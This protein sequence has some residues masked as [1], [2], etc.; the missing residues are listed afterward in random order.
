MPTEGTLDLKED[1]TQPQKE[2]FPESIDSLGHDD[3]SIVDSNQQ[4]SITKAE[5]NQDSHPQLNGSSKHSPD[6][7]DRG[8]QEQDPDSPTGKEEGEKEPHEVDT[9]NDNQEEEREVL[10]EAVGRA[11]VPLP[12]SVLPPGPRPTTWVCVRRGTGKCGVGTWV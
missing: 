2:K 1:M 11:A 5:E 7:S 12:D 10:Q 8:N 3:S 4:E 9:L 6:L